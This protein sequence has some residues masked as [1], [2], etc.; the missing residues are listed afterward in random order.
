MYARTIFLYFHGTL[1][2]ESIPAKNN[3]VEVVE[4]AAMYTKI[5]FSKS[6]KELINVK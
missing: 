4:C 2:Q 3:P 6:H 5:L 1:T